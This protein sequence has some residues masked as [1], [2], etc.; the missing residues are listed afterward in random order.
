MRSTN[1]VL[2]FVALVV[3][4]RPAAA[5]EFWPG[6]TYHPRIPT[7]KG[8]IG[9]DV[10]E[11]ISSPEEITIYLRALAAAAPDRTRLVEYAK[12]WEGRPLHVIVIGAPERIARL[13]AIKADIAR[14]ADPRPLSSDESAR[15]IDQL[16]V[17]VHLEHA[18]HGNEISSS[19]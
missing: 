13:D 8:G 5:Q 3:G 15:L 7:L 6:V 16:P 9:H 10:G 18:V 17:V 1:G 19:D 11:E 2:L 14:L 4:G 12:T